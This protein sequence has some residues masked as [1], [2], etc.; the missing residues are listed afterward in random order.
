MK[1]LL[2]GLVV[3]AVIGVGGYLY[4]SSK[5]AVPKVPRAMMGSNTTGGGNVFTS[6]KDA[7]SK[8]ISLKCTFKDEKGVETTT[9]IKNGA[10]RVMLNGTADEDAP[11][12]IVMKDK[13]MHMWSDKTKEG[14]ILAFNDVDVSPYP[15]AGQGNKNPTDPKFGQQESILSTIEKYKDACKPE[16]VSDS[17]FTVPTDV[18]FQDMNA[19][20]Q[21]MMKDLPKAPAQGSMPGSGDPQEYQ[22]YIEGMMQQQGGQE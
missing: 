5:G 18:K 12:N 15:T 11:N 10:V 22:K 21:Q 16:V 3:L 8:S 7:L 1:N 6:I 20:Q 19:L 2:I 13:Q 14:I 4:L 17:M 9:Y